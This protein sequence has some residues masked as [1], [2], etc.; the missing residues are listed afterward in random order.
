MPMR[1][2]TTIGTSSSRGIS[3]NGGVSSASPLCAPV[4]PS[5]AQR[6]PGP[7]HNSRSSLSPR[8]RRIAAMPSVGSMARISTALAEPSASQTKFTHQWMP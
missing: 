6:R 4:M 5:A 2:P 8:R 1:G 3:A 7:E